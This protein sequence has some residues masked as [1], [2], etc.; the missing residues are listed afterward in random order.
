MKVPNKNSNQISRERQLKAFDR[1]L[2][3]MAELRVKCPWDKKQ[4]MQSLRMKTIEEVYELSEAVLNNKTGEIKEELGDLMLHIIFY[5]QIAS[6][7]KP[8]FNPPK[9][10]KEEYFDIAD[11]LNGI[12]DKLVKRHPHIYGNIIAETE[13]EVKH[14]WEKLK[15]KHGKKSI[16]EGI[17]KSIPAMIKALRIQEK[18]A[19]VGFDW[20]KRQLVWDK[21]EEELNEFKDEFNGLDDQQ[22]DQVKAENEFGDLLFSLVNYARFLKINP[23]DALEHTNKKVMERFQHL[24]AEIKKEGKKIEEMDLKELDKY[25]EKA[26][27]LDT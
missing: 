12:C 21:I 13:E 16:L 18:V 11:A 14:N 3:I 27:L 15:L 26:K 25:W 4:T 7:T 19:A 2:S 1:L 22:I 5:A 9:G 10:G 20:A 24:E 17:P 8:P 23:E 6:E